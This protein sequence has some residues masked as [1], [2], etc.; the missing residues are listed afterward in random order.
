M[1]EDLIK[2]LN[3]EELLDEISKLFEENWVKLF[4]GKKDL[5]DTTEGFEPT[6]GGYKLEL[7][8]KNTANED[9]IK[10]DLD[11]RIIRI[12]YT[13]SNLKDFPVSE[14]I[15]KITETLP[16]DADDSTLDASV[17][18]GKLLVTVKKFPQKPSATLKI[19]RYA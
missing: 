6:E 15:V 11:G 4:S 13:D 2:L 10:I 17:V 7:K 19:N 14:R 3:D 16:E 5:F 12:T 9:N 18:D 8:V 1:M